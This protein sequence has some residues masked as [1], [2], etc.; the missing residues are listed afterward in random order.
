VSST[1]GDAWLESVD[2]TSTFSPVTIA[3]GQS[4]TVNVTFTPTGGPG[5]VVRGTLYVDDVS[6]NVPPYGTFSA[7]EVAAVPYQYTVRRQ[8]PPRQR[9]PHRH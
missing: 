2:P 7:S 6:D 9:R 4:A 5:S 8:R 3:P 1:T